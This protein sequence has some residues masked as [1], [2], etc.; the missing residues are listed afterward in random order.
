M[1]AF[2]DTMRYFIYGDGFEME[3]DT[4]DAIIS[5][6]NV[7]NPTELK[8]LKQIIEDELPNVKNQMDELILRSQMVAIQITG[9]KRVAM[10]AA[11]TSNG[12]TRLIATGFVPL[13]DN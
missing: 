12:H 1:M 6:F 2:R 4:E 7:Y 9:K 11:R 13:K 8:E 3:L 10:R 5:V